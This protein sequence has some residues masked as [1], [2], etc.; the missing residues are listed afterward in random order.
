M[1]IEST[2][3]PAGIH[4]LRAGDGEAVLL[5]HGWPQTSHCW[6]RVIPALQESHTVVA[7]DLR[8][9]GQSKDPG[10]GYDKRSIANDLVSFMQ[11]DLG[12]E[13]FHVV[14]HDWGG[15]VAYL[16]AAYHP[17][18]VATLAVVDVAVPSAAVPLMSQGGRRWHHPFH[19]TPELPEALVTGRESVYLGWFFD[20]YGATPAAICEEDR[21]EYVRWY[22]DPS[23]LRAGFGYYRAF[24]QDRADASAAP[25]ISMPVLAV[26]GAGGWG[27]A[28]EVAD[29]LRPLVDGEVHEHICQKA[30]HW[31]PEE[32][33]AE[34][35]EVVMK[36]F[37]RT[38]SKAHVRS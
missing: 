13:R 8:G 15:V 35:A 38:S 10:T 21:A 9:L 31:I 32:Q 14:G 27:R 6:R 22:R 29:S 24:E 16:L 4:Y 30:G 33:P 17:E 3:S 5:L 12:I 36:H 26:G 25:P 18:A 34:L 11:D 1:S 19:Q 37:G 2:K 7:P 23:V 28:H 20:N